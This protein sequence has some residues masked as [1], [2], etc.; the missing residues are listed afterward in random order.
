M[1]ASEI[2]GLQP[3]YLRHNLWQEGSEL[4]PTTAEWSERA[5]P[6]PRP[7]LSEVFNPIA[8]KTVAD[9]PDLFQINTPI[10]VDIFESFLEHHPNPSFVQSVCAGLREGFWP[11]ADTRKGVFPATH[12]ESRPAPTDERQA[13]FLRDQC[14]KERQKGRFS[15]SFGPKLLPGMYS[16]PVHA[17]PKPSSV[18]LRLVM[19]H[20]AG[21]F[22]LNSMIDHSRVTGFPL[23]NLRHLGEML[24]DMRQTSGDQPLTLWKSDIADAYRLLPMSPL[25]Q[26]KQTVSIDGERYVDRNLAFRSSASAAIFISFNS[27]VAWIAKYVKGLDYLSN[28]VDDSSGCASSDSMQ[29]YEPYSKYLPEPQVR[30]LLLWDEL[31]IL[32]KPHKQIFG[33]PLPIIGIEV[34]SN[35]MTLTLPE[36]AKLRLIDELRYWTKK[37]PKTS[38]GSFKLKHWERLA[39]W[40]NWALNVFPLLRPALNNIYSKMGG[41]QNK[42]QRVYINNAIRDDLSWALTHLENSD[43]IH[44]FKSISWTPPQADCTVYCDAC[45]EGLGFWYPDFKEGYYAPTPVDVPSGVIFYFEALCVLSALDHVQTKAP[46]GSKVLLYTD[47]TNTVDIFRSLRCLPPYNRLL[48]TAVD[49]LIQKDYSLRVLHVPGE[50]NVVAD[51]LSR[52][53]FSI[54]LREEPDLKFFDFHPPDMVGSTK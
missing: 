21:P 37:P 33:C 18:D 28:Y 50:Q 36:S 48:K 30:L 3:K 40:F 20:S 31:G 27:L 52:V 7:P 38:S 15:D 13:S 24:L 35:K 46:R 45:P 25:W 41:K 26:L 16:M 29:L 6:L 34:D 22:S 2:Y 44:L 9:Y 12:D 23:D 32:H 11:W 17:V 8:A 39:G 1:G 10:K 47:N 49:I 54:A 42:E 53:H 43:G 14:L 5:R 51:A 4:S 19:D